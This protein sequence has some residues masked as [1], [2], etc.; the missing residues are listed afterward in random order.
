M[1]V[2]VNTCNGRAFQSGLDVVQLARNPEA[3]KANSRQTKRAELRLTAW[4]CGITKPVIA[5]VNCVCAGAGLHLVADASIVIV[6][7]AA[8][9][10]D[11]HVSIG[12]VSAFETIA[13]AKKARRK[14]LFAWLSPPAENASKLSVLDSSASCRRSSNRRRYATGRRSSPK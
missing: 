5:A 1:S 9:F 6:S 3:L 7:T 10:H 12:Q 11:P 13:R 4:H 8:T 14:P 2:I